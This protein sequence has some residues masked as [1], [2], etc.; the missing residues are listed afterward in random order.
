MFEDVVRLE[1][2]DDTLLIEE[3]MGLCKELMVRY[4][5]ESKTGM[6]KKDVEE[7]ACPICKADLT[8]H[9]GGASVCISNREVF[10]SS[11]PN[12]FR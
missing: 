3:I 4:T 9:Y 2:K 11:S 8:R 12:V 1:T 6:R 10:L 7:S 5:V